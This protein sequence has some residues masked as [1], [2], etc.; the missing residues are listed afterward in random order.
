MDTG[1]SAYN[2]GRKEALQDALDIVN[3][4]VDYLESYPSHPLDVFEILAR[5]ITDIQIA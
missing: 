2:A 1:D 3:Q 4:A 5:I